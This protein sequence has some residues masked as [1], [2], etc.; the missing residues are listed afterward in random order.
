ME[1]G[2][3]RGADAVK[4][5]TYQQYSTIDDPVGCG[6]LGC[7]GGFLLGLFGGITLVAVATLTAA[8]AA[9]MPTLE[10]STGPDLQIRLDEGF[11]NRFAEQPTDG[12]IHIDILP[13][14]QVAIIGTTTLESFGLQAPVQITGIFELQFS[15]NTLQV[16]LI[17]TEVAGMALPPE[18]NNFFVDDIPLINANLSTMVDEVSRVLGVPVIITNISTDNVHIQLEIRETP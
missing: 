3:Y 15:N 5:V 17:N 10:P 13:N 7:L 16:N 8:L 6:L 1:R 18:L 4:P 9:P 2:P 12:T 14:N 11:I